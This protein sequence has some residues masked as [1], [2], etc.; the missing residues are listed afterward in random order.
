VLEVC[1]GEL[2]I[3]FHS[4]RLLDSWELLLANKISEALVNTTLNLRT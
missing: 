2:A 3:F 1:S 4:H